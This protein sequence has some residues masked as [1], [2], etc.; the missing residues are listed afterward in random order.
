VSRSLLG[1]NTREPERSTGRGFSSLGN[2][3]QCALTPVRQD[4]WPLLQQGAPSPLKLVRGFSS[5]VPHSCVPLGARDSDFC[6]ALPRVFVTAA[7]G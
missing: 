7:D 6:A 5:H 2:R 1:G 4:L 3:R